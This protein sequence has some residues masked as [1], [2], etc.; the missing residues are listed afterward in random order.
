[1]KG[2]APL[3]PPRAARACH[4]RP[5]RLLRGAA[6]LSDPG[7][8]L[9][10]AGGAGGV[11]GRH[12][13]RHR[14][15]ALQPRR[16]HVDADR[17]GLPRHHDRMDRP[18]RRARSGATPRPRSYVFVQGSDGLEPYA[19]MELAGLLSGWNPSSATLTVRSYHVGWPFFFSVSPSIAD[20]RYH[21]TVDF[22]KTLVSSYTRVVDATGTAH[23]THGDL[24]LPTTA[25][26]WHS[27]LHD[28]PGRHGRSVRE[29]GRLRRPA[30]RAVDREQRVGAVEAARRLERVHRGRDG[31]VG[32]GDADA[33][34]RRRAAQ[35]LVRA[36]IRH[37]AQARQP[38]REHR[39][40]LV[41]LVLR[42]RRRGDEQAR[43]CVR[44]A[45]QRE[46]ERLQL[47]LPG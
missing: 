11:R 46:R 26:A 17:D 31:T 36:D 3:V 9:A 40:R 1:M 15:R 18:R 21:L 42:R 37:L 13:H 5:R 16:L 35:R 33:L 41:H 25:T 47:L 27:V 45:L 32:H 39:P 30:R 14:P 4:R 2:F 10:P 6:R 38:R 44:V 28:W 12:D 19:E 8:L 24:L 7:R 29:L 23:P 34:E 43:L 20:V 22:R